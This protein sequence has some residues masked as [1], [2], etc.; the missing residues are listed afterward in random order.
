MVTFSMKKLFHIASIVRE[1]VP[2]EKYRYTCVMQMLLTVLLLSE[3]EMM[4]TLS[5][6]LWVMAGE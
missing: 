3:G 6:Y 4:L 2:A 1:V 5:S